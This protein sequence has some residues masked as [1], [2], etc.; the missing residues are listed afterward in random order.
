MRLSAH[1]GFSAIVSAA[2]YTISRSWE[3]AASCLIS[4]IFIDL[5]HV[6]DFFILYGWPFTFKKFFNVFYRELS[7]KQIFIVLHA[8]EW[9]ILLFAAS[10]I[11]GWNPW[12]VGTLIGCGH[13]MIIDFINNGGYVRSYF[14]I[15]RWRNNFDFETSFPGIIKCRDRHRDTVQQ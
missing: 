10:W 15:W 3:M 9:M 13:H 12:F 6:I 8:W 5:D 4:G 7:F 14:L 1:V 2:L 11:T